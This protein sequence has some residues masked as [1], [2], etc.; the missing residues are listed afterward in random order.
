MAKGKKILKILFSGTKKLMKSSGSS[1]KA[2]FGS[3]K[4][5]GR[6]RRGPVT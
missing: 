5:P 2:L 4:K 3:K 1:G 6:K